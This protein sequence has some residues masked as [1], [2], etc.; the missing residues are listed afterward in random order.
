MNNNTNTTPK[1]V[2]LYLLN[3]LTFYIS[4]IGFIILYVQYI[5]ALFPDPL[6]FYYSR[7]AGAVRIASSI[8]FVAVP[9]Y[10]LTSWLLGR[11]L[12]HNPQKREMGLR[13]WLTYFTLFVSAIT[14]IV[15]LIMV[16]NSFL[17]GELTIQFLLKILTVLLVAAAV[18][19]Y[20][21]W[22]LKRKDQET[23]KTPKLLAW[24]LAIMVL[25][26]IIAGFFIIGTPAEQRDR[27]FDD[28]RVSDLQSLQ[29]QIINYW[30][31]KNELPQTLADLQDS[32]SGFVPPTDPETEASYE[33]NILGELSFELCAEFETSSKEFV[34]SYPKTRDQNWEHEKGRTCFK[35]TIDPELYKDKGKM[36]EPVPVR[37]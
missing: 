8:L 32:I 24:V 27:R 33:Y 23:S 16:V 15:T 13:K 30:Q 29:W 9:V 14:I 26:S 25:G 7:V 18:F 34:E 10:I 19:G 21:I 6:S 4:V 1:D 35:R 17:S 22:D 31:Q 28:R 2:F 3:I 36:L 5:S 20:Y 12:K 11:D 37:D